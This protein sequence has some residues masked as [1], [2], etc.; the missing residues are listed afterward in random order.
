MK[1][2]VIIPV[3]DINKT[4]LECLN[5]YKKSTLLPLEIIIVLDGIPDNEKIQVIKDIPVHIIESSFNQGPALARNLGASKAKGSILYF[6][7]SDVSIH[8]DTLEKVSQKFR[9]NSQIDAVIG[10]YDDQPI[11]QSTLS[12]YRN[13][14]HHFTHQQN[15]G[16]IQSFWGACGTIKKEVFEK[17]GGFSK[18]Y[19]KPSIEDIELGYRVSKEGYKIELDP[20]IQVKHHKKWTF[21]NVI[22]TDLFQRAI[23]W[24]K[25]LQEYKL[26]NT[27]SLNVN[28]K[29]KLA[30]LLLLFSLLAIFMLLF[31]DWKVCLGLF[32]IC[33]LILINI[34]RDFFSFL[35]KHFN[36]LKFIKVYF[37]YNILLGISALGYGMGT[38]S[39]HLKKT[40]T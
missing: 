37:Y 2:S 9:S 40:S 18:A 13:L 38:I 16:P 5:S 8:P 10:S 36:I 14:L 24:T 30:V 1:I 28:K 12:K 34:K 4:F 23:P 22:T 20:T 17:V 19:P 7:D 32:L 27:S 26:F 21:K 39:Y 31:I 3:H 11:H 6:G 33:H 25:L 15:A 35:L 29:E